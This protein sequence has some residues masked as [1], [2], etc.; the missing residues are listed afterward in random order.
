MAANTAFVVSELDFDTLKNSLKTYLSSQPEFSDYNFE[1]SIISTLINLL[2]Y[3]TYQNAYYLNVVAREAYLDSAQL[4]DSIVSRAK[5]LGYLPRSARGAT[6]VVNVEIT[7]N[8]EPGTIVIPKNTEFTSTVNGVSYAFVVPDSVSI[9]ES[10]GS[11]SS[12]LNIVEGTPLTHSYTVSSNNPVDYVIPNENVDT[13]SIVVSV[14]E[15][16]GSAN[17]ITYTQASDITS[18]TGTSEVYFL[19]ATTD[20]QYEIKFGDGTIGKQLLNNNVVSISYRVTNG[21][22][23]NLIGTFTG[24]STLGGYSDYT[25]TVSQVA[26]GGSEIET[27]E[28]IKFNAPR[29]YETQNRLVLANDYERL[30]KSNFGYVQS[31]SVWGGEENTPP[32]YGKV[33]VAVKPVAGSVISQYQKDDIDTFLGNYTTMAIDTEFVDATYLYI[34]PTIK[35][36]YNGNRLGTTVDQLKTNVSSAI[37]NFET[38]ELSSFENKKFKYSKFLKTIDNVDPAIENNL[39]TIKIQK[40]FIPNVLNA[41]TYKINFNNAIKRPISTGHSTHSGQHFI[42]SSKFTYNNI[43]DCMFDDDGEGILR[44]YYI[45]NG[46]EVV[47]ASEDAGIV[48][49]DSG[50]IT[51]NS[52]LPTSYEDGAITITI[53]PDVND[54]TALRNQIMLIADSVVAFVNTID[55]RQTAITRNVTTSGV[56]SPVDETGINSIVV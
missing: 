1:S 7:P 33:Y 12:D 27:D 13:S 4:R 2:T 23:A 26:A 41:T 46:N 45:I 43:N 24:P 29:N 31:V 50:L 36:L 42:N 48:D 16:S 49:Y 22:D 8:D 53:T 3:N 28:S 34:V 20:N 5:M 11:F 10:N 32:I 56:I 14:T 9:N 30:I 15:F 38:N 6:A 35:V 39:T 19:E 44:I 25:F 54:I 52:F 51:I 37:V 21:T 18:I 47:Y 40:R 55:N 17:T